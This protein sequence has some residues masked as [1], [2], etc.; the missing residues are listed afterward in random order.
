MNLINDELF[1]NI[2][3]D[4]QII[5]KILNYLE[6]FQNDNIYFLFIK[7]WITKHLS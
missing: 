5:H 4:F 6:T 1:R 7:S 3:N 2:A